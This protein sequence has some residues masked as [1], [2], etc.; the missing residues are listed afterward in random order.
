MNWWKIG[1]AVV[2][3]GL[4]GV[5][6]RGYLEY[7]EVKD[8]VEPLREANEKARER[9]E[10]LA[11]NLAYLDSVWADRL[12]SLDAERDSLERVAAAATAERQQAEQA[13]A[14]AADSLG[15]T[16]ASLRGAVRPELREVVDTAQKQLALLQ[17]HHEEER[18]A[19]AEQVQSL[20]QLLD[21]ARQRRDYW[22]DR[23]DSLAAL[24]E[25]RLQR[26]L[27]AEQ[28]R[29][30]WQSKAKWDLLD[31]GPQALL[32]AGIGIGLWEGVQALTG[33]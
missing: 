9:G 15:Q 10:A 20:T 6:V 1:A 29:D 26:A 19:A 17:K 8:Q 23:S 3:L 7:R 33:G 25:T 21:Q 14:A 5:T 31:D 11:E 2:V 12:D 30:V 24:A 4:I 13:A 28:E 22:R 16:L 18:A 27:T 32:H